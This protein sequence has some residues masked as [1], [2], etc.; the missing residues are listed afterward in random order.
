MRRWITAYVVG[1]TGLVAFVC[2]IMWAANDF[3]GLPVSWQGMLAIIV[4]SALV[5]ALSIGLM[6][7]VF[8]SNRGGHDDIAYH[9]RRDNREG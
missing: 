4:G 7:A 9:T 3:E 1:C 2:L 5:A 6:A 8:W